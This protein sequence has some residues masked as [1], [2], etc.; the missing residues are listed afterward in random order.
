MNNTITRPGHQAAAN[1][2]ADFEERVE[3]A[4]GYFVPSNLRDAFD[5]LPTEQRGDFLDAVGTLLV[6]WKV[7]GEPVAEHF[8]F[9]ESIKFDAMPPNEQD[10]LSGV[11]YE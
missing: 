6:T 1:W 8:D 10:A 5:H 11:N 3:G 2:Y 7:C 9:I 4:G